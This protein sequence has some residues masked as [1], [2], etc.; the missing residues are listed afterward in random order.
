MSNVNRSIKGLV[1]VSIFSVILPLAG[2][3]KSDFVATVNGVGIKTITMETAVDNFIESQELLGITLTG[4]EVEEL[5]KVILEELISAELLYQK[6]KK[7]KLG[8]LE[9]DINEQFDSIKKGIGSDQEFKDVL[10]ERAIGENDLKEDIRK[11]VYI[12][13]FLDKE[14]YNSIK[15]TEEA[16]KEE[17]EKT[18]DRLV[19]PTM[20]KTQHILLKIPA[21]ATEDEKKSI[22][23][24]MASIREKAVSGEDFGKLARE[25]SEDTSSSQ[26]GELDYFAKDE[27]VEPFGEASFNLKENEISQVVETNYGYHIIKFLDEKPGH[28]LTYDEVKGYVEIH[29]LNISRK[30]ALDKYVEELRKGAKIV[31]NLGVK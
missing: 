2:L 11:G 7:A 14:L 1:I 28:A 18:K 12:K 9:K 24:K 4:E 22:K 19:M 5:K 6:S 17:Y 8:N 30:E 3:A 25:Y 23:D 26:D 27:V 15:I 16:K 21:N 20:R 10:K 13:T 31:V 29:L